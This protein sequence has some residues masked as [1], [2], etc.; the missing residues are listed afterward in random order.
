MRKSI[1][2]KWAT[3][4]LVTLMIMSPMEG[5]TTANATMESEFQTTLESEIAAFLESEMDVIA[6]P[7]VFIT[8]ESEMDV[9][10]ESDVYITP[11][12]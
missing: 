10:T 1:L 4:L 12:L 6:E 3:V 2:K 11:E 5:I 9:I 8:S 7:E